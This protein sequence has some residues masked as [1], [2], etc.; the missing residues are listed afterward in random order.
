[1]QSQKTSIKL[2]AT[3]IG[4]KEHLKT[5]IPI[6]LHNLIQ[7]LSYEDYMKRCKDI[8]CKNKSEHSNNWNL[9]RVKCPR[10]G[11]WY[12]EDD[13]VCDTCGYPWNE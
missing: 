1:M 9:E 10:C 6:Y 2:I 3:P 12:Y 4:N 8:D 5:M 13:G 11:E 7:E